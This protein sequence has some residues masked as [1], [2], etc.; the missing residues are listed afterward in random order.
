MNEIVTVGYP[1]LR[2]SKAQPTTLVPTLSVADGFATTS[3]ITVDEQGVA[4]GSA[5]LHFPSLEKGTYRIYTPQLNLDNGVGQDRAEYAYI[6][7]V[8]IDGKINSGIVGTTIDGFDFNPYPSPFSDTLQAT[9]QTD[10][11][12][13]LHLVDLGGNIVAQTDASLTAG[14][15]ITLRSDAQSGIY[16]AVLLR[17]NRIIGSA[18][19]VKL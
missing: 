9:V 15:P 7:V 5:E 12:Y 3:E 10:G 17:E 19:V 11:D 4:H 8:D 2:G 1:A 6:Y 14:Q 16:I 13:T 18:K